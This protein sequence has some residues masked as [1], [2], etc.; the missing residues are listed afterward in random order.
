VQSLSTATAESTLDDLNRIYSSI[1]SGIKDSACEYLNAPVEVRPEVEYCMLV[2]LKNHFKFGVDFYDVVKHSYQPG[3]HAFDAVSEYMSIVL[4]FDDGSS[5]VI[6]L[7]RHTAYSIMLGWILRRHLH[8]NNPFYVK[9]E[10][11][12]HDRY[13][14]SSETPKTIVLRWCEGF[15]VAVAASDTSSKSAFLPQ[16][17]NWLWCIH[18]PASP[19]VRE[20]RIFTPLGHFLQS[21]Y[22]P[23]ELLGRSYLRV[24]ARRVHRNMRQN[25]V[26]G[27]SRPLREWMHTGRVLNIEAH[28]FYSD[29]RLSPDYIGQHKTPFHLRSKETAWTASDVDESLPASVVTNSTIAQL[30]GFSTR[31]FQTWIRHEGPRKEDTSTSSMTS[32]L[33][34]SRVMVM[35]QWFCRSVVNDDA[36]TMGKY[37]T[38]NAGIAYAQY[39]G[40]ITPVNFVHDETPSSEAE[41]LRHFGNFKMNTILDY[42]LSVLDR[43]P[44]SMAVDEA[45]NSLSDIVPGVDVPRAWLECSIPFFRLAVHCGAEAIQQTKGIL[46]EFLRLLL[47]YR[48]TLIKRYDGL[49]ITPSELLAGSWLNPWQRIFHM[50]ASVFVG[51]HDGVTTAA[52]LL[53]AIRQLSLGQFPREFVE[54]TRFGWPSFF[55]PSDGHNYDLTKT[56]KECDQ[57]WY[58]RSRRVRHYE[59]KDIED[60]FLRMVTSYLRCDHSLI[61][62]RLQELQQRIQYGYNRNIPL[63]LTLGMRYSDSEFMQWVRFNAGGQWKRIDPRVDIIAVLLK[64]FMV[65]VAPLT[66]QQQEYYYVA[67]RLLAKP[68]TMHD[69]NTV[70]SLS[71]WQQECFQLAERTNRSDVAQ[72]GHSEILLQG[73][74]TI[75][76]HLLDVWVW[77]LIMAYMPQLDTNFVR[78]HCIRSTTVDVPPVPITPTN[79]NGTSRSVRQER[80]KYEWALKYRMAFDAARISWCD[81]L[82]AAVSIHEAMFGLVRRFSQQVKTLAGKIP[83][84]TEEEVRKARVSVELKA[85]RRL[86]TVLQSLHH[87]GEVFSG[88][89]AE[90]TLTGHQL[91]SSGCVAWRIV[92]ERYNRLDAS[93]LRQDRIRRIHLN[94]W[95]SAQCF[96]NNCDPSEVV[97][98]WH[99]PRS[100]FTTVTQG[101]CQLNAGHFTLGTP[102]LWPHEVLPQDSMLQDLPPLPLVKSELVMND[103]VHRHVVSTSTNPDSEDNKEVVKSKM[104]VAETEAVITKI[105]GDLSGCF[106]VD[107]RPSIYP[108]L[109]NKPGEIMYELSSDDEAYK[110]YVPPLK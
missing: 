92:A 60:R 30:F 17:C 6:P 15:W 29:M 61:T 26:K 56:I 55:I 105:P 107:H 104:V 102:P 22:P 89:D 25:N 67:E 49:E 94:R 44:P 27:L 109:G 73:Y 88:I 108:I 9:I 31:N 36:F 90:I 21:L 65:N 66:K 46:S 48:P 71:Q 3:R 39:W 83:P 84:M 18:S 57:I 74:I 76:N 81:E 7:E 40:G 59:A 12:T 75:F 23:H 99:M 64:D 63:P 16:D 54:G 24:Q 14:V 96:S 28:G 41:V 38:P 4:R 58:G 86:L 72:Q 78:Y 13:H 8:P 11:V 51:H 69:S 5:D 47:V 98:F 45:I 85:L 70:D 52:L 79:L 80:Q 2:D 50:L 87:R 103:N 93:Q 10:Y 82:A 91:Y 19:N 20:R 62:G 53:Q 68:F 95:M 42:M 43:R 37:G 33:R 100:L 101:D 97:D 77:Q 110:P 34:D 1:V 32:T 106:D 35:S